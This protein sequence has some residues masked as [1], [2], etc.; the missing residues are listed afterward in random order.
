MRDDYAN[1]RERAG[2]D[3][4]GRSSWVSVQRSALFDLDDTLADRQLAFSVWAT[5]FA[6]EHGLGNEAA[7]WLIAADERGAGPRERFFRDVR[8]HFGPAEAG[9]E[10]WAAFRARMPD[11]V[12]CDP[13][14][15]YGLSQLRASGW[16]VGIVSNGMADSQ[17]MIRKP[18]CSPGPDSTISSSTSPGQRSDR[19]RGPGSRLE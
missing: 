19:I 5:E 4:A 2:P 15:L 12:R 9:A 18:R 16:R 11:L 10:L 14:V 17:L 1:P 3:R 7:R 6:D 13:Q 8:Q